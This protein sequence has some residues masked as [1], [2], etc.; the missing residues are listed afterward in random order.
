MDLDKTMIALG[1]G[2]ASRARREDIVEAVNAVIVS[3]SLRRLDIDALAT[4]DFKQGDFAIENES[5]TNPQ[6]N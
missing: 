4:G 2:F 1:I 6:V 5:S 3:H